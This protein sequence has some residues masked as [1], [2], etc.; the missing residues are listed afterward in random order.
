MVVDASVIAP[1]LADDGPDGD[2]VCERLRGEHLIA[3]E[4]LDLEVVSVIRKALLVGNIAERKALLAIKDL[5][6]IPIKRVSHR[7]L[8]PRVWEVHQ[9]ITTYDAVYIALAEA[10]NVALA[11]AD[12]RPAKAPQLQCVVEYLGCLD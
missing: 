11:T 1:A 7:S 5:V 3:P 9:Y 4:L 2:R 12:A 8:L 6:D 10:L